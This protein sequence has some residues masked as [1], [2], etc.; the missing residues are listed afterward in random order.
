M[1]DSEILDKWHCDICF[2]VDEQEEFELR[3][4][5]RMVREDERE[6]CA[7]LCD[8]EA[9]D[10]MDRC[11]GETASTMVGQA[12]THIDCANTLAEA[13]RNRKEQP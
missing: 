10:E 7:L 1:T 12:Q 6:K 9:S 2:P 4:L 11:R 13:I 3:N 8:E 5:I